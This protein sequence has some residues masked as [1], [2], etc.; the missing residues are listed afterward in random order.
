M[1]V[2]NGWTDDLFPAPEAVR[3]YRTVGR[4]KDSY[5]ALQLADLGHPRGSNKPDVDRALNDQGARFLDD[6][7]RNRGSA[8]RNRSVTAYTQTCPK[9]A[10]AGGPVRARS[11]DGLHPRELAMGARRRQTVSSAAENTAINPL[12]TSACAAF[13]AADAAGSA[14]IS[15]QVRR[16]F[17][18]LGFPTVR[19]S[20]RTSGRGGFIAARLWDV[21]EGNQ[22]LVARGLYRLRDNQRGR[23]AFQLFGNGWRF[24]R[25][26]EAKLELLGND[27]GFLRTSN[28]DFSVRV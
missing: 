19:A 6:F 17:T 22:T 27:P 15:R 21:H 12:S 13:P 4:R 26:H 16:P 24:A 7:L 9:E 3:A 8:P 2:M 10:P 28:F 14:L 25:G 5:V 18:L 1:L 23:I 11:W 20:I